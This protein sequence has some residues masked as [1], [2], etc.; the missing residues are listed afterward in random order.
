VVVGRTS[1]PPRLSAWD[2]VQEG[3][4]LTYIRC[5][6]AFSDS[7]EKVRPVSKPGRFNRRYVLPL[8]TQQGKNDRVVMSGQCESKVE[9]RNSTG[10]RQRAIQAA[11]HNY[12]GLYGRN[13]GLHHYALDRLPVATSSATQCLEDATHEAI[14]EYFGADH[15]LTTS[16]GYGSNLLACSATLDEKWTAI[17]DEKSHNSLFVAAYQSRAQRI[18]KYRHNDMEH[19]RDILEESSS[20]CA[21]ILVATDGYLRSVDSTL[22]HHNFAL[23]CKAWMAPYLTLQDFPSSS[24]ARASRSSLTKLTRFC[25]SVR[26]GGVVS[27]FGTRITQP[28]PLSMT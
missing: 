11:S 6:T 12:I 22:R 4:R 23:T 8:F 14:A 7:N 1:R 26:L 25:L 2:K 28:V 5:Q 3:A 20:S 18:R 10:I 24:L 17:L 19:L 27:S 13:I 9:V 15:C 16:T 21:K